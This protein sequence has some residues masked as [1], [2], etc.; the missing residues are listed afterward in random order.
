MTDTSPLAIAQN[1]WEKWMAS[2]L[3]AFVS[4]WDPAGVWTQSGHSQMSGSFRGHD[5]IIKLAQTV[6][7]ISGGT[8]KAHPIELVASGDD[9]VLGYAHVEATRPG[10]TLNQ[11]VLQRFVIQNGRIV[12]LHNLYYDQDEADAFF[13]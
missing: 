10:A 8:A 6:F 12:S 5:G 3:D 1:A 11:D 4:L 9:A 2:D 13:K 7:E